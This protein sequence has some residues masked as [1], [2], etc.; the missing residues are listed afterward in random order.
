M[1]PAWTTHITCIPLKIGFFYIVK[2]A[3]LNS[4]KVLRCK[5]SKKLRGS[6]ISRPWRRHWKVASS[7]DL[8]LRKRLLNQLWWLLAR[9]AWHS[10]GSTSAG[11]KVRDA[12][13]NSS[14]RSH[15]GR[16]R[17]RMHS[18]ML[19]RKGTGRKQPGHIPIV[20]LSCINIYQRGEAGMRSILQDQSCC[21]H[22]PR[23]SRKG[24][25]KKQAAYIKFLEPQEKYSE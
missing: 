10:A 19:K 23:K 21:S 16:S 1:D 17:T 5:G 18:Y 15:G 14:Q 4:R 3:D 24:L 6:A 25:S 11:R 7:K 20:I 13:T 9:A 12:K 2:L 8:N 22:D